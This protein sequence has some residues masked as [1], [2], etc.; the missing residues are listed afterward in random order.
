MIAVMKRIISVFWAAAMVI[1]VSCERSTDA[2][3]TNDC[4]N[5][6]VTAE[7]LAQGVKTALDASFHVTWSTSDEIAVFTDA[8]KFKAKVVSVNADATKA[9]VS[10]EGVSGTEVY[11]A[12][13]PF[14]AATSATK[15]GVEVIV[16]STQV[17]TAGN[18]DPAAMVSFAKIGDATASFNN[19][20]AIAEFSVTSDDDITSVTLQA[21]EGNAIAGTA[22]LGFAGDMIDI[23]PQNPGSTNVIEM[24][25]PIAK[26]TKYFFTMLPNYGGLKL[27]FTRADGKVAEYTYPEAVFIGR[28]QHVL[29]GSFDIPEG[30]WKGV[31]PAPVPADFTAGDV[32]NVKGDGVADIDKDHHMSYL[33][34][35]TYVPDRT[36]YANSAFS[37]F[38]SYKNNM[39]TNPKAE[40]FNYWPGMYNETTDVW[41]AYFDYEIFIS[42]VGGQPLYIYT[43]KDAYVK[44]KS[45]FTWKDSP[46][47]THVGGKADII[48]VG[49]ETPFFTV[50]ESGIYRIRFS[51]EKLVCYVSKAS[52]VV[53]RVW[54]PG[55]QNSSPA[56]TYMGH[57][58]WEL[59]STT[60]DKGND[61][62]GGAGYKFLCMGF[63][64]DQPY[65]AQKGQG[66]TQVFATD[67]SDVNN[68]I[69]PVQGGPWNK[70]GS[71]G[72]FSTKSLNIAG[73]SE[74]SSVTVHLYLNDKYGFYTHSV[75]GVAK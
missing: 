57:G 46:A 73:D 67:P 48:L 64:Q 28:N 32:F 14:S 16:P 22:V 40:F 65:G 2:P 10:A 74:F 59:T 56:M 53:W 9:V 30:A 71:N 12:V 50:P 72:T 29:L 61:T 20:I 1:A 7:Q 35:L 69:V 21:E 45:D 31:E 27:T 39:G 75:T 13:T 47:G 66:T 36:T 63:D 37:D 19:A 42:L 55:G 6:V 3:E 60:M 25:G 54:N 44:Q 33:P 8:G 34:S 17:A 43:G 15:S 49:A 5:L 26:N 70:D 68:S 62:N 52:S 4:F 23:V 11:Y 41:D 24:T 18:Y 51:T 58:E 38:C